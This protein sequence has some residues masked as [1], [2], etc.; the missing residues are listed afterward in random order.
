MSERLVESARALFARTV[1][2]IRAVFPT[3]KDWNDD[4]R[5]REGEKARQSLF[6]RA[7]AARTAPKVVPAASEPEIASWTPPRPR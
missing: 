2:S 4:L 5:A 6:D 7:R 3:A 1:R